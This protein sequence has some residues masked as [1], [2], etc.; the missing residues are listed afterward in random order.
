MQFIDVVR[1]R[2]IC[3]YYYYYYYYFRDGCETVVCGKQS[4]FIVFF[5]LKAV[6]GRPVYIV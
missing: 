5:Y 3:Y 1:H 2:L 6:V 4:F